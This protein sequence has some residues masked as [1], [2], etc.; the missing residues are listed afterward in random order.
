MFSVLGWVLATSPVLQT[1]SEFVDV[2]R[3]KL[4]TPRPHNSALRVDVLDSARNWHVFLGHLRLSFTG[5]TSRH[6]AHAVRF[7]RREGRE[8]VIEFG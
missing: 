6:A 2:L 8:F 4:Q 3:R 1:P 5:F 7:V